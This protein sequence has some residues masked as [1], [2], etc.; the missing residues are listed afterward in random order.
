MGTSGRS[1]R[2]GNCQARHWGLVLFPNPTTAFPADCQAS[3]DRRPVASANGSCVSPSLHLAAPR[4]PLRLLAEVAART[5]RVVVTE[6]P[7]CVA[8]EGCPGHSVKQEERRNCGRRDPVRVAGWPSGEGVVARLLWPAEPPTAPQPKPLLT[9]PLGEVLQ[10]P[11][12]RSG[13]NWGRAWMQGREGRTEAGTQ[14]GGGVSHRR[15]SAPTQGPRPSTSVMKLACPG[16]VAAS[17]S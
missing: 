14:G 7:P 10:L 8:V 9:L 6:H 12:I 16:E 5:H 3:A 1:G 17:A 15:P 4:F 13:G 11:T 2:W